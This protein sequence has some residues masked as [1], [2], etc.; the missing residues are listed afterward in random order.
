MESDDLKPLYEIAEKLNVTIVCGIEERDSK[1]SQ[2]TLYNSVIVIDE[3]GRL[4]NKHRKLMPT[5]PR[6]NGVGFW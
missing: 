5:N 1:L 2:A 4:L 6:T 3:D